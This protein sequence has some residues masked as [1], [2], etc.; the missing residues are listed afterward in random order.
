[1]LEKEWWKLVDS[2]WP[3]LISIIRN[4]H[5]IYLRKHNDSIY[6]SRAEAVCDQERIDIIGRELQSY[7]K[8]SY[9]KPVERAEKAKVERDGNTLYALFNDTWFGMP[10]SMASREVPGFFVLCDLCSDY[11]GMFEEQDDD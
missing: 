9:L 3:N 8:G 6:A 10:E 2:H 1:M 7:E 5:P 4:F 11:Y